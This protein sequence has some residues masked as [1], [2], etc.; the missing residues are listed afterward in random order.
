MELRNEYGQDPLAVAVQNGAVDVV[1]FFLNE[2]NVDP[3]QAQHGL[4]AVHLAVLYNQFAVLKC[5]KEHGAKMSLPDR[6]GITPLQ[7]A[8]GYGYF[9]LCQL[10]DLSEWYKKTPTGRSIVDI[11]SQ[12][13]EKRSKRFMKVFQRAIF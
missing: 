6:S 11:S 4:S 2:K 3:D 12:I 13:F 1:K 8:L 9:D 5:L 7:M 10:F